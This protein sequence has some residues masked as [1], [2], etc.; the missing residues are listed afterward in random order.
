MKIGICRSPS[1][2]C[3]PVCLLTHKARGE[4]QEQTLFTAPRGG[5]QSSGEHTSLR[6][7]RETKIEGSSY[8]RNVR[9][10]SAP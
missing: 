3:W 10:I 9:K 2:H 4:C 5:D 6:T 1:V 7:S 8:E